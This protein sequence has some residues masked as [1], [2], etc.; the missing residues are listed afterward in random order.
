MSK[1][2]YEFNEGAQ[3]FIRGP[4]GKGLMITPSLK[5]NLVFF[6][7]GTGVL[8]FLDTFAYVLRGAVQKYAPEL[9]MLKDETF[10]E[11]KE[12]V[13]ISIFAYFQ[14]WDDAIGIEILEALK[15]I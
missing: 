11:L 5:G 9:N 10:E 14:K 6:C 8:P 3:Y 7:G 15:K 4:V 13:S 12:G 1:R 2:L